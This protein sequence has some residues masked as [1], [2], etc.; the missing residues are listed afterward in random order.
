M[1]DCHITTILKGFDYKP[2]KKDIHINTMGMESKRPHIQRIHLYRIPTKAT[3][4]E[5]ISTENDYN[6][7]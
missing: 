5:E 3:T 6:Q 7:K 1:T 4:K 2:Q